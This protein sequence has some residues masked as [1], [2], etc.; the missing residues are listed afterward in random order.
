MEVLNLCGIITK[1]T[2]KDIYDNDLEIV[3]GNSFTKDFLSFYFNP[4]TKWDISG[5]NAKLGFLYQYEDIARFGATVQFPKT[6]SISE[7]YSQYTSSKFNTGQMYE[8][9]YNDKVSYDIVTPFELT[10][11]VAVNLKGLI[12]SFEA[13]LIDYT[14]FKFKNLEGFEDPDYVVSQ[15]LKDAKDLFTTVINY[16][17]GLEYTVPTI[18]LRIRGGFMNQPSAF[19]EDDSD[20]DHKYLTGG[21]GFLANGTIGIDVAYAYGWWKDIGDN[22]GSN[23]S[24]TFQDVKYHTVMLT[25]TYRF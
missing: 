2:M 21:L 19:K 6:F 23:V 20:F 17:V 22:Y 15:N 3:P 18:G 11:A 16:N 7:E 9:I 8:D 10:G 25:T 14:Q 12:L 1:T 24:R 13:D 4:T 5:W